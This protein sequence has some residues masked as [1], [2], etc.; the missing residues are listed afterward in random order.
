MVDKTPHA[1]QAIASPPIMSRRRRPR[2]YCAICG[3]EARAA[4][5][6]DAVRPEIA[7]LIVTDHPDLKPGDHICERHVSD[8]RTRYVAELLARERGEL[9]DLEKQV[10]ESLAREETVSRDVESTWEHHRTLGERVADAVADFGGSWTFIGIFFAVLA[11]WMAFNVW[12]AAREVFDPYPF[13]L[14]NLVLSCLAAI[15][16]PII[17][18]SQNRQEAKDRLRSENDFRVNLKAELEIRQ[19]HEKIDHLLNRQWERLAEIQQIQ[20][21]MMQDMG[22]RKR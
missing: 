20:L 18:M 10:V 15:Q 16:A 3:K 12:S 17:M 21:E 19:L 9:S 8:Y 2:P 22:R 1:P 4:M 13:I 5:R 14:L 11:V 7:G 6:F